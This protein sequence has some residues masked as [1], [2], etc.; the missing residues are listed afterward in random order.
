MDEPDR[1]TSTLYV[2]PVDAPAA[3]FVEDPAR[4]R[5]LGI[6]YLVPGL[7]L[8]LLALCAWVVFRQ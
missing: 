5:L 7:V 1:V 3:P 8:G 6:A 2:E 4:Q